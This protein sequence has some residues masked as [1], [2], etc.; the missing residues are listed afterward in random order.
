MTD[1]TLIPQTDYYLGAF[2]DGVDFNNLNEQNIDKLRSL[3]WKYKVLSFTQQKLDFKG[4]TLAGQVFGNIFKNPQM[5]TSVNNEFDWIQSVIR[6]AGHHPPFIYGGGWH[7][8]NA[9]LSHRPSYTMIYSVKASSTGGET[10]FVDQ[11][12]AYSSSSQEIKIKCS[13]AQVYNSWVQTTLRNAFFSKGTIP[14]GSDSFYPKQYTEEDYKNLITVYPEFNKFDEEFQS[15]QFISK[16]PAVIVHPRTKE[17]VY[18]LFP[19][20]SILVD[21]VSKEESNWL[22]QNVFR[23]QLQSNKYKLKWSDNMLTIWDNRLVLHQATESSPNEDRIM[24]RL[25]IHDV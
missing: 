2:V 18:N 19:S 4:L 12:H 3:L 14:F 20:Y 9:A 8:D 21:D 16:Q 23:T 6:P 7:S 5:G 10:N 24:F 1:F 25:M 17:T 13:T 11:V 22:L 15:K